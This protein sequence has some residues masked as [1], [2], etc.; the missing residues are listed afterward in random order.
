[1]NEKNLQA[2]FEIMQA[3]I[4]IYEKNNGRLTMH[5]ISNETEYSAAEIFDYFNSIDEIKHFYFTSLV[6]RYEAMIDEI[7]DFSSYT[8]SEK[9][10]NYIYTSFDMMSEN[11][12]FVKTAFKPVI[13][14]NPQKSEFQ[15]Q[16]EKVLSQFIKNDELISGSSSFLLNETF[17]KI[18]QYKYLTLIQFW[19]NDESDG[20]ETTMELT[21][22]LTG[23]LQELLYSSIAD[24]SLD[25]VKFLYSNNGCTK[26]TFIN[27]ITS[28]FEF[29]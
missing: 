12:T 15:K 4:Q 18:L 5:D 21:D 13:F 24:R 2:K 17:F 3:A 29:S 14:C 10:C 27:R 9:L 25:L 8:L 20:K 11:S 22:K 6:L 26:N 1:M 19:I 7:D 16:I 28:T 23:L